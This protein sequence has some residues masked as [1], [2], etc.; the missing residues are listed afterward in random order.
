MKNCL[1]VIGALVVLAAALVALVLTYLYFVPGA[2]PEEPDIIS[3]PSLIQTVIPQASPTSPPEPTPTPIPTP[4]P[5]PN[6]VEYRTRVLARIRQFASALHSFN[7]ANLMLQNNPGLINDPGWRIE[8][9]T[10]LDELVRAAN[11]MSQVEPIPPEYGYV[12]E[13]LVQVS[14]E[15]SW[16]RENYVTAMNSGST[17]HFESAGENLNQISVLLVQVEAAMTAAGW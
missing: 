9:A 2:V 15:T 11:R 4:T 5:V 14:D 7:D 12:A 1:A 13:L 3:G 16:L 6:P 8:I 17:Q 10:T